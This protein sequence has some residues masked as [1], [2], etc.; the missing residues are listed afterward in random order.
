MPPSSEIA[1]LVADSRL[2]VTYEPALVAWSL[3]IA[4]IASYAAL[5]L[6][7]RITSSHGRLRGWWLFGGAIVMGLGIWSMHFTGMLAA[8]VAAPMRYRLVPVVASAAIA[9]AASGLALWVA[10]R[11]RVTGVMVGVGGLA[12]GL[13]IA[14]MH[15]T[16]MSSIDMPAHLSYDRRLYLLSVGIAVAAAGGAL[17]LA[18]R[19]RDESDP[20]RQRRR[21]VAALVM[22]AGF[23]GMHY[24]GMAAARFVVIEQPSTW[25]ASGGFD[26]AGLANLTVMVTLLVLGLTLVTTTLDRQRDAQVTRADRQREIFDTALSTIGDLVY[27]YDRSGR[28]VYVNRALT[29]AFGL[30]ADQLTGRTFE[31]LNYPPELAAKLRAQ[32]AQVIET[33]QPIKDESPFTFP[34]GRTRIFEYL[35]HPVMAADGSCEMVAGSTRD[36]TVFRRAAEESQVAVRRQEALASFGRYALRTGELAAVLDEAVRVVA[37]QLGTE[38][39]KIQQVTDDGAALRVVAGTGWRSQVVGVRALAGGAGSAA[40]H[41]LTADAPVRIDDLRFETRFAEPLLREHNVISGLGTAIPGAQQPWGVIDAYSSTPRRFG[42]DDVDFVQACAALVGAAV[43]RQRAQSALLESEARHRAVVEASLDAI[44]TMDADG[45]ITG[46]NPAA[47]RIFG[48]TRGEALGRLLVDTIVAPQ[49]RAAHAAGLAR[50]VATGEARITGERMELTALRRD[51]TE[52]PVEVTV[53]R[54]GPETPPTFV[55]FLRDLTTAHRVRRELAQQAALL[56][57]ARDVIMVRD[58]DHRIL[59]L[60]KSAEAVLGWS[61]A[62]AIGQRAPDLFRSDAR[63]YERATREVRERG[64]WA[65]EVRKTTRAGAAIIMDSR[66]TVVRDERGTPTAVMS[67]ET[68]ITERRKLELQ[69]LRAQRM[70]GIG[71]LAG[72]IAHDLNNVL[73]PIMMGVELLKPLEDD[74]DRIEIL[75]TIEASARRGAEMVRQVLSFARG[76]DGQRAPVRVKHLLDDVA[77][78]AADTFPKNIR[79]TCETAA[80]LPDVIGDPTQLHQVLINLCVNA[81]DAMPEGGEL[82][83]HAEQ[84]MVDEHY[85]AQTPDARPGTYVRVSVRDTGIGVAE[86]DLERIFE[87]FFTTKPHGAGTGL[88]LSTSMAIVKSHGGFLHANSERGKGTT[89]Q[90]FVPVSEVAAPAVSVS[91][92][93]LPR[94]HGELVLVVDDEV[95]VREITRQTLE[96]F[97]YRV[98]LASDGAEA[99]ACYARER[100]RIDV[101]LTDMMMP[102]MDGAAAI[103]V[104]FKM[105]PEVRIIAASGLAAEARVADAAAAGV[106]HFL[107]KPYTA[108]VL[109]RA[110]RDMLRPA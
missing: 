65:G 98:M 103:R 28:L 68:D 87:P 76:V 88:G 86:A 106:R 2:P 91:G 93:E 107:P 101:V 60:N 27:I 72:G 99:I 110:L 49:H 29:E 25:V 47:E 57:S 96:S 33:R 104:L 69:F 74:P 90:V 38:F 4:V 46:F 52:F 12:M 105:N 40:G 55:G 102:V 83:L 20:A 43:E 5:D 26:P 48:W 1:T 23:S 109:L 32:I 19:F 44:I 80:G 9:A 11:P 54:Q 45:R 75:R 42:D 51:G 31:E 10:A 84:A 34:T 37:S 8:H 6:T 81:R 56:D 35:I 66:W 41:I 59:Y 58:F 70:E 100:E 22:G 94:G 18:Y 36:I 14:G 63:A 17:A 67:I 89:M 7:A 92:P 95:S 39:C 85:A 64:E 82:R 78:I 13:A 24:V 73:T 15:Y 61:A 53:V 77:K 30:R 50:H 71:T 21:T 108:D 79:V 62:E 16:G 3:V 97:G